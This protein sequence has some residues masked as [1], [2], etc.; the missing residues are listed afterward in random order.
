MSI[1][2]IMG[3]VK[4]RGNCSQK[5][6]LP[7][8]IPNAIFSMPAN[9]YVISK[10]HI[11]CASNVYFF[12]LFLMPCAPVFRGPLLP[13]AL[14]ASSALAFASADKVSGI[15]ETL[16]VPTYQLSASLGMPCPRRPSRLWDPSLVPSKAWPCHLD[17]LALEVS[18]KFCD[19][20]PALS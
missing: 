15:F 10:N 1:W 6:D 7:P 20:L 17:L 19:P 12:P 13:L 16:G 9:R 18:R 5:A 3:Q 11:C 14:A 8:I 2:C 4:I